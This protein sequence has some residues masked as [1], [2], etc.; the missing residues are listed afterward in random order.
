MI[1]RHG[2]A[3]SPQ[4]QHS[5]AGWPFRGRSN[6]MDYYNDGGREILSAFLLLRQIWIFEKWVVMT[7][8]KICQPAAATCFAEWVQFNYEFGSY[9]YLKSGFTYLVYVW[10]GQNLIETI[11]SVDTRWLIVC[12]ALCVKLCHN[13]GHSGQYA[14]V[15]IYTLPGQNQPSLAAPRALFNK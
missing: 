7:E 8:P 6:F 2:Q 10:M 15:R 9:E 13:L 1:I 14:K 3:L 12:V 4:T 11:K 5:L